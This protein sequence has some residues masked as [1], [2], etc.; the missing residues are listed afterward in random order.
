M[1]KTVKITDFDYQGR[2]VAR[3]DDK[4]TFIRG[5]LLDEIVEIEITKTSKKFDEAKTIKVI[6]KNN[7]RVTAPCPYYERCGGCDLMH[8][9]YNEALKFKENKVKNTIK[10]FANIET[11]IK[12]IIPAE[13][14][15]NYR[16]KV[17][18]KVKNKKIGYYKKE[19]NEFIEINNC[20]ICDN[21]EQT[22]KEIKKC[23]LKD[24]SEII[25]RSSKN[26]L[27]KMLIFKA[28]KDLDTS[29]L[30]GFDSIYLLK[31]N[32][33]ILK[34]GNKN[35]IEIMKNFQFCISPGAFFQVNTNQAIKLYD[36]VLEYAD[37]KENETILDLYSG[38][39]TIGLYLSKKAKKIIGIEIN[40]EAIKDANSN[41][42]KNNIKNATFY[43]LNANQFLSKI[44]EKIDTV[45]VDPPRGGLDTKTIN[46]ILKI[47]PNKIVYVSCDVSTLARD[48]KILSENYNVQ[49][50]T[51]VDMFP[52]TCHV[53]CVSVLHR[54]SLE[55]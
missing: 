55:K 7:S 31:N 12:P 6:K 43:A 13:E 1:I 48:L 32:Q 34:S 50:I 47:H 44:K 53:E 41:K 28:T 42:E 2:G 29:K 3:I 24:V 21:L 4:V 45:I 16:N 46:S 37:P 19:S 15:L 54:K 22:L 39:G 52:N 8:M 33:Y 51:P 18:F 35:I 23:D 11:T 20:L 17:T 40:E 25:I 26:L 10:K 5:A 27:E 49:E 36:K 38:T 30:K 14:I 9:N